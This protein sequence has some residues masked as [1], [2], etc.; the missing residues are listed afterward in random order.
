MSFKEIFNNFMLESFDDK[1]ISVSDVDN[2]SLEELEFLILSNVDND[3]KNNIINF[4][5]ND[6]IEESVFKNFWFSVKFRWFLIGYFTAMTGLA[7]P[8]AVDFLK[9]NLEVHREAL[10]LQLC[11]K[12]P[13][14]GFKMKGMCMNTLGIKPTDTEKE[15]AKKVAQFLANQSRKNR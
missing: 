10:Q 8:T 14:K 7:L 13:V 5:T 2:A 1:E 4:I 11:A 6:F 12:D 9:Q 3:C 15:K